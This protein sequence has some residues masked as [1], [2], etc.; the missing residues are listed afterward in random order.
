MFKKSPDELLQTSTQTIEKPNGGLLTRFTSMFKS[1]AETVLQPTEDPFV[2]SEKQILDY[3]FQKNVYFNS[4]PNFANSS[5]E[6]QIAIREV[7]QFL[8]TPALYQSQTLFASYKIV[9]SDLNCLQ[10]I[11]NSFPNFF[12]T[13]PKQ[14]ILDQHFIVSLA[15]H[16]PDL[17]LIWSMTLFDDFTPIQ[18][19]DPILSS[20]SSEWVLLNHYRDSRVAVMKTGMVRKT[21]DLLDLWLLNLNLIAEKSQTAKS[22]SEIESSFF[23]L[24]FEPKQ[25]TQQFSP[26]PGFTAPINHVKPQVKQSVPIHTQ[27]DIRITNEDCEDTSPSEESGE[28]KGGLMFYSSTLLGKKCSLL[29]PH[30]GQIEIVVTDV[31]PQNLEFVIISG[32]HAGRSSNVPKNVISSCLAVGNEDSR[33]LNTNIIQVKK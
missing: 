16:N 8:Q 10:L 6:K 26:M 25:I 28:R 17:L 21:I 4:I 7:F 29:H 11:L 24:T 23:S 32:D 12:A 27:L 20:L 2:L 31:N 19:F 14:L 5:S 9:L 22:F 1:R 33:I 15:K 30:L 3:W 18:L 13:I